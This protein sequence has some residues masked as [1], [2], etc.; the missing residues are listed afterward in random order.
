M[1]SL[2]HQTN[3]GYAC[4]FKI[5]YIPG[6]RCIMTRLV[7]LW[8]H[9]VTCLPHAAFHFQHFSP[10]LRSHEAIPSGHACI[11][12]VMLPESSTQLALAW[13]PQCCIC[14]PCSH[15]GTASEWSGFWGRSLSKT[16]SSKRDHYYVLKSEPGRVLWDLRQ[17]CC[18]C[19][20]VE[21]D[22]EH[23]CRS[24]LQNPAVRFLYFLS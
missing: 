4:I 20:Q 10:L 21:H 18:K 23:N 24:S 15:Q 13:I 2:M 6:L 5:K 8:I 1:H 9:R 11:I 12:S 14:F 7:M 17:F 19:I 16:G 22:N 3:A